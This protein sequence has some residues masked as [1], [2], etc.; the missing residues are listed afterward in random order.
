MDYETQI[1]KGS[2]VKYQERLK[3]LGYKVDIKISHGKAA[4]EI[5]K[6]ISELD[7]DLLVMGAHGH[8]GLKDIVFGTT[9]NSVRHGIN[10]PLLVVN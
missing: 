1:D 9:V 6:V 5:I 10:I 4:S 7:I 2:L 8:K 3:A